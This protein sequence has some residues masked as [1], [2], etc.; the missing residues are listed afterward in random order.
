VR[1]VEPDLFVAPAC[2]RLRPEVGAED[3][4]CLAQCCARVFLIELR[5]EQREQAVAAVEAAGSRR[6]EEGEESEAPGLAEEIPHLAPFDAG[7][8]HPADQ[9]ELDHARP[10]RCAARFRGSRAVWGRRYGRRDGRI[11]RA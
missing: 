3:V 4:Q 10:R 9:A 2:H 6:G 8:T 1:E 5:P 11:T 7:E